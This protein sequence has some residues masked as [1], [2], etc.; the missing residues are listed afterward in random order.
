ML[1][2]AEETIKAPEAGVKFEMPGFGMMDA[3]YHDVIIQDCLLVLAYDSRYK[4]GMKFFPQ[5]QPEANLIG[6]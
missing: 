5:A 2:Q 6:V 4:A 3:Y 1:S